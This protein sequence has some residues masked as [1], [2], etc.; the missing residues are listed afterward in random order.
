[1]TR[2]EADQKEKIHQNLMGKIFMRK[3]SGMKVKIIR[4]DVQNDNGNESYDVFCTF[5]RTEPVTP[6]DSNHIIEQIDFFLGVYAP[7]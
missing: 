5:T 2:T 3:G 4:I 1:M 6:L 7:I